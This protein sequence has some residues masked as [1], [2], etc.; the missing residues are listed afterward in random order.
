MEDKKRIAKQVG[1][2]GK[3]DKFDVEKG[4]KILE[5]RAAGPKPSTSCADQMDEE[6]KATK[7]RRAGAAAAKTAKPQQQRPELSKSTHKQENEANPTPQKNDPIWTEAI[8]GVDVILCELNQV[9]EFTP[10]YARLNDI[11]RSSFGQMLGDDRLNRKL[12]VELL[13]YHSTAVLWAR[14]LDIKAKRAHAEL[15][16]TERNYRRH[17]TDKEIHLI[18]P[19]YTYL[20]G[21]GNIIDRRGKQIYLQDHDLPTATVANLTGYHHDHVINEND[22][23]LYEEIPTLGVCGDIIMAMTTQAQNP[24]PNIGVL[25]Q[26]IQATMNLL[27]YLGMIAPRRDEIRQVI[28]AAQITN[29]AFPESV[30]GTRF[31]ADLFNTIDQAIA[32]LKTFK[33]EKVIITNMSTETQF[34][35]TTPTGADNAINK[36][37]TQADVQPRTVSADSASTVGASYYAGYQLIKEQ[38]GGSHQNWCCIAS[39]KK[40]K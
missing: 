18:Q 22:H 35:V 26:E 30:Q 34:V 16:E 29:L 21:I 11:I 14:L 19:V 6:E 1:Y 27:S 31:N 28:M 20:R 10:S 17:F 33:I 24:N 23:T 2:R 9:T 5:R 39:K 32:G 36:R 40:N 38:F 4:K 8:F 37:W 13:N 15:S 7:R 3:L 12:I 25:P